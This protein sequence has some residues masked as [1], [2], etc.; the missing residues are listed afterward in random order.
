MRIS[1]AIVIA[2]VFFSPAC[3]YGGQAATGPAI[4]PSAGKPAP[5]APN[6][7]AAASN[8]SPAASNTPAANT[9]FTPVAPSGILQRSLDEV[10][11]TIG[12][13][14]LEKW[15]R[16]TVRDE[17]ETNINA[18]QRD[19][20]GTL[21]AL[22]KDADSAPGTLSKVFPLA[23]NVDALYDV[24]LHV[25]EGARVAGTGGEVGQLQQAMAD[26]EKARIALGQQILQTA[27]VQE[28]QIVQLRTTVQRQELSLRAAAT[29]PPAPKCPAPPPPV[30][31]K[32]PATTAK[33]PAAGTSTTTTPAKPQ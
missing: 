31:K 7:S 24:L 12:G 19:M 4:L 2:T 14:R 9:D 23:R 8:T 17:A 22:M 33:K 13:V 20:Q 27:T 1:R 3:F 15:R 10:H 28:K 6:A 18:I 11:Q 32:R 5:A 25:E 16:G 29:P 21:P 30:K 26:L